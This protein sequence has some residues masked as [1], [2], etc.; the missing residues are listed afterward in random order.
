MRR[1]ARD[2]NLRLTSVAESIVSRELP[3]DVVL[4][5]PPPRPRRNS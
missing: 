5:Q 1:Y 2:R 4:Q 3:A